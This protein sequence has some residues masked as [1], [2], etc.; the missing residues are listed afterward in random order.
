M[1]SGAT[2]HVTSDLNIFSSF[3]VYNGPD[4]LQIGND[5]GL[6][7]QHIGSFFLISLI[8]FFYWMYYM[9][10]ISQRTF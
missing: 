7:I 5:A 9:Y 4:S 8:L 1:D 6:S 3:Y 10:H 2:N